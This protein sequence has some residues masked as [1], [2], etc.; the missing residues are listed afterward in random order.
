MSPSYDDSAA[1]LG[2]VLASIADEVEVDA[3]EA[4]AAWYR[5]RI[6]PHR[7]GDT[8][9]GAVVVAK[10]VANSRSAERAI[11]QL[12]RLLRVCAWCG[13]LQNEHGSWEKLDAF[14]ARLLQTRITHGL[15]PEC[16]ERELER[17]M[18]HA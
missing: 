12:R 13:R 10:R 4:P 7:T 18:T 1:A 5:S 2:E 11:A 17:V 3:P 15:C 6:D 8:V 9:T 14:L 16:Y